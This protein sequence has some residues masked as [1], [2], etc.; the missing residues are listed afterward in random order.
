[1]GENWRTGEPSSRSYCCLPVSLVVS[2][3]VQLEAIGDAPLASL[4]MLGIL[5]NKDTVNTVHG[6]LQLSGAEVGQDSHLSA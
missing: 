2:E 3:H 5:T 1:M 6:N 4:R